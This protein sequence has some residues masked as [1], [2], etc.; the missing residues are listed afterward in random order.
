V[1]GR[2]RGT[3][4][5]AAL[6]VPAGKPVSPFFEAGPFRA[7][8]R[9]YLNLDLNEDI[10]F[11]VEGRGSVRLVLEGKPVLASE[12]PGLEVATSRA[13]PLKR[14][15][16][17]FELEY[18]SPADGDAILRLGWSSRRM[19]WEP[20]PATAWIHDGDS[21]AIRESAPRRRGREIFADR[22]CA[23]CHRVEG[24]DAP[25]AMPEMAAESASL[26]GLGDR[27]RADW[28]VSWLRD[29]R[30][31]RADARM[32]RLLEGPDAERD[33]RDLAAAL[34]G[35]KAGAASGAGTVPDPG[36]APAGAKLFAELGCAG[37]HGLPGEP[38]PA[39]DRRVS[40]AEVAAKWRPEALPSFLRKPSARHAW[41]RMP[42][43]AL[44]ASE[45]EALAAFL[46]ERTRRASEPGT[47]RVEGDARR[48]RELL[49]TR[50]CLDCHALP[51]AISGLVSP[52]FASLV[53]S[54]GLGRG[55]L[56]VEPGGDRGRAPAFAWEP[57]EREALTVFLRGENPAG[58][59]RRDPVDEFA[60]RQYS[61][62]RCAACHPRDHETDLLSALASA[63][64]SGAA[65]GPARD[66]E[67]EGAEAGSVHGGRP[68][69][70][71]TGEKLYAGWMESLFAGTLGSK[72]RPEMAG[73]MPAF[74][75]YARGLAAGLAAQHGHGFESAPRLAVDG[76]KAEV[77]RRLTLVEGGFSCVA[78]HN[79]GE[80][81]ALAGKDTATVNFAAVADRLRPTYYWRYLRDPSRVVP[82]TM[83]PK[84]IGDDGTTPIKGV[85]DGDPARQF[86]AVWQYLHSL[87]PGAVTR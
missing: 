63:G 56:A 23:R 80:Q 1:A 44:G 51:G 37:C 55:C 79:V 61:A 86:E 22:Q 29:P 18:T 74:P 2:T 57:G 40:L 20:V 31:V 38:V 34:V 83:M 9:G 50:G 85:Y 13:V 48:G 17:R 28:L 84:F 69:L 46:L 36:Q 52:T 39:N 66:E 70:S 75:A 64:G 6:H 41:T 54:P 11:S 77:G 10:A 71:Y 16:N 68:L 59:L 49:T 47:G 12:G 58:A 27:L 81:R 24:G 33:A 42:D 45:A 43:F 65:G 25:A 87:R 72:T 35:S 32:P 78:C 76:A 73:R 5:L 67:E 8:W 53:R 60:V 3:A 26:E 7:R 15:P 19:A 4:R 14:G 30:Q 21:P 82:A 62:L